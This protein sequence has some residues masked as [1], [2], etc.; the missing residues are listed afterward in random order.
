MP[1]T[2]F[3]ESFVCDFCGVVYPTMEKATEC[4]NSHDVVYV[5]LQRSDLKRLLSFI[6]TGN[7]DWISSSLIKTLQKYKGLRG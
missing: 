3:T 7:P 1:S 5:P 6:T 4:E 2:K